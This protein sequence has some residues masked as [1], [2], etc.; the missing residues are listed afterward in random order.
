[1]KELRMTVT[2]V[3]I[4]YDSRLK[5]MMKTANFHGMGNLQVKLQL[6][7]CDSDLFSKCIDVSEG[8]QLSEEQSSDK[9]LFNKAAD[10][11]EMKLAL[12]GADQ[13]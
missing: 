1:M 4:T 8:Q 13:L 12:L 11:T 2:A 7:T 6:I 5:Q 3:H 10:S 9:K